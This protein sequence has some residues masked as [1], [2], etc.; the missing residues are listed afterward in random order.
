MLI[1]SQIRNA[2]YNYARTRIRL[3]DINGLYYEVIDT[4]SKKGAFSAIARDSVGT[5]LLGPIGLAAALSAKNKGT[6]LVAFKFRNGKKSLIE[7][8][9]KAY[10]AIVKAPF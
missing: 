3:Q 10:K 7:C 6:Y 2:K 9:H 1:D 5:F 8:D 4:T